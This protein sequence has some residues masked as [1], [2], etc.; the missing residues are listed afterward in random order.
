ME[1][2][3]TQKRI[4]IQ[5]KVMASVNCSIYKTHFSA[6]LEKIELRFYCVS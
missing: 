4:S 6:E 5:Q 2:I 1:E 3:N